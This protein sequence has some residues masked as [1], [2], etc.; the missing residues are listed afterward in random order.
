MV[1]YF[2]KLSSN[3]QMVCKYVLLKRE[4]Y[5]YFNDIYHCGVPKDSVTFVK[6][7]N[8]EYM[9]FIILTPLCDAGFNL[10]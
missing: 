2:F 4:F 5:I 1:D 3:W 7:K 9:F 10:L 8:Y 6:Y